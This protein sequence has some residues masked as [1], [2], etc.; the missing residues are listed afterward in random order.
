LIFPVVGQAF[1]DSVFGWRLY[2]LLG[3]WLMHSGRDF[4]ASEGAPVVAA[5]SGFVLSSGLPGGYGLATELNHREPRRR[6]LYGHL[7]KF[8][9][10]AGQTVQQGDVIGRVGSTGLST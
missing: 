2:P 4:A 10:K 3:S 5:L 6:T 1:T 8:Y 7:S 9:V